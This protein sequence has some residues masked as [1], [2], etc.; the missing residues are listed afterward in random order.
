MTIPP[1]FFFFF[2][3]FSANLQ[4]P[5]SRT[6]MVL[7]L[8]LSLVG[9]LIFSLLSLEAS[10]LLGNPCSVVGPLMAGFQL[11]VLGWLTVNYY[12]MYLVVVRLEPRA[13]A[14]LWTRHCLTAWL[15]PALLALLAVIATNQSQLHESE[16]HGRC[17]VQDHGAVIG[18]ITGP[19]IMVLA[20]AGVFLFAMLR[21]DDVFYDPLSR[22]AVE[23][24][25]L[26]P[27]IVFLILVVIS[28]VSWIGREGMGEKA[29]GR[30][31][32]SDGRAA[33]L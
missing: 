17:A 6:Y 20:A 26:A 4:P 32:G 21:Q 14:L 30:R 7:N 29:W 27:S 1:S 22:R 13:P 12:H 31:G 16:T 33:D 9:W 5:G 3:F 23:R 10:N 11:A 2:F 8:S 28:F 18:L 19:I 15:V 24:P 25:E